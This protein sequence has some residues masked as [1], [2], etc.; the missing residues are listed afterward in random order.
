[1]FAGAAC[2]GLLMA[3]VKG[4]GGGARDAFGNISA[5]WLLL[6]FVAGAAVA[7]VRLAALFGLSAALVA[8]AA[9]YAGESVVLDLGRH[10]WFTDLGLAMRAG[11]F[12][13]MEALFSGPVFGALGG[14]WAKRRSALV[15]ATVALLFAFE[16]LV[17]WAEHRQI[18]GPVGAGELTRY[19]WL[20]ASEVLVGLSAAALIFAS[21]RRAHQG[22][23]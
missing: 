21:S 23:R 11:R 17:V 13:V 18:G 22:Q 19:P 16:P 5:P 8:L 20:W 7:R 2:F 10:P 3:L 14:I 1:V 6:S 12:Y 4:Q 9:F 15:A